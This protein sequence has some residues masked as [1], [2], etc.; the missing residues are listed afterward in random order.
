MKRESYQSEQRPKLVLGDTIGSI[1]ERT[2][3]LS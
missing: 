1:P 3:M 2:S